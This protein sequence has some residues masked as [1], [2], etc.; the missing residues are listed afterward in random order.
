MWPLLLLYGKKTFQNIPVLDC[1]SPSNIFTHSSWINVFQEF[2]IFFW[3]KTNYFCEL[4]VLCDRNIKR[5]TFAVPRSLN[6][7]S[8]HFLVL[9]NILFE[10]SFCFSQL[11]GNRVAKN[12]LEVLTVCLM[13]DFDI[14]LKKSFSKKVLLK[15]GNFVFFS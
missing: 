11:S 12:A 15:N 5:Y 3:L 7:N 10:N 14:F 9:A 13:V 4:I 6:N 8:H 1:N 2:Q